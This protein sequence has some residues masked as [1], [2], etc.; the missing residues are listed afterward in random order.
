MILLEDVSVSFRKGRA[1][2]DVLVNLCGSFERNGGIVGILGQREAGKT[3]LINLLAG[4][5]TPQAGKL[6]CHG[7][8]SWVLSSHR[9]LLPTMT[10][11]ANIRFIAMLYS[12]SVHGLMRD[13]AD[14]ADLHDVM[15]LR[16]NTLSRDIQ[17]R[18]VYCLGLCLRFDYY[19]AD[20]A[21]VIGDNA[22]RE[23][24]TGYLAATASERTVI[25]VSRSPAAIK[26][27]CERAY[28]LHDGQLLSFDR[29][30][31][32]IRAFKALDDAK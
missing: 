19:L 26:K 5:L 23:K 24:M 21:I 29:T 18:L 2:R 17:S 32:A 20:E 31:Q 1:R 14:L 16:L 30:T 3:T 22:F 25:L 27:H 6:T 13:V 7:S 8:V 4:N 12:A 28:V 10:V 9:P 11:R 15:D